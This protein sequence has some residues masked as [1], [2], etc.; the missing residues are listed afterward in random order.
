MRTSSLA[1]LA[2]AAFLLSSC[3]NNPP[4]VSR[5]CNPECRLGYFCN[6]GTCVSYCN[7]PCNT[8]ESCVPATT[9]AGAGGDAA[10]EIP[11][12]GPVRWTCETVADSGQPG[13][14]P[15]DTATPDDTAL[16][17]DG[18][19]PDD[20]P[21]A[22]TGV[23]PVDGGGMDAGMD[24]VVAMD[25]PAL[26]VG[27]DSVAVD[28][29]RD[30]GIDVTPPCGHASERCCGPV[31]AGTACLPGSICV[32]GTCVAITRD[33]GECSRPADCPSGQ[34][35]VGPQTCT[36]HGCYRC[37]APTGTGV[38]G[39]TCT[40]GTDC[41]SGVCARG[42]CTVA[43]AVGTTG[44]AD[45][46]AVDPGYLC[47]QLNYRSTLADGG[48]SPVMALGLCTQRCAR[49]ADCDGGRVCMP[50]L[51]YLT[52]RMDFICG[53]TTATGTAGTPCV[54]GRT[55][56]ASICVPGAIPPAPDASTMPGAACT[57]P[58]VM[59]ADCPSAAP[60]C[61]ELTYLRPSG[62]L[63]PGRGCLPHWP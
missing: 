23:G 49:N 59:N 26:D 30:A 39:A 54:D 3:G 38:F 7:P 62:G 61:V 12:P 35:C 45:C 63:Q 36:D 29:P 5:Y 50:L 27:A 48:Y 32:T 55:C 57:A 25:G 58:C 56:Q 18:P 11:A 52:D 47:S 37:A 1:I 9:D 8:G 51:N 4:P 34:S 15:V 33:P 44:D 14:V 10:T 2:G 21:T 60:D 41:R 16:P 31:D 43:C 13:D 22:D 46:A 20:V 17:T 6:D 42:R 28:G 24:V 19:A 53:T 40:Y